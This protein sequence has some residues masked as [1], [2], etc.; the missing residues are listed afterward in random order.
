MSGDTFLSYMV[1]SL[2]EQIVNLDIC[3]PLVVLDMNRKNA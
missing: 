3:L 1:G 2:D